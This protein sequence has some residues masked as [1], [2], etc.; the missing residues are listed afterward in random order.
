MTDVKRYPDGPGLVSAVAEAFVA[1]LAEV[2][3]E[4]GEDVDARIHAGQHRQPPARPRIG[5]VG[6]SR[7]IATVG[8][9]EPG[10]L[11]HPRDLTEPE[12]RDD[13]RPRSPS[14]DL[15]YGSSP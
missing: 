8:V 4:R 5:D 15:Q 10:D 1:R 14:V 13:E 2:Q 3:A 12:W 6:A 11:R 7:R 9:D